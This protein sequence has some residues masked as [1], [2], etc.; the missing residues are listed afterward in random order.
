[1]GID[2]TQLLDVVRALDLPAGQYVV[3]GSGPLV[4]RGLREGRDV[5]LVVTPEL[6]ERLRD[7]GWTV[8]A[9][10]DGGE[11]LQHGD[12]EAMTR[13]EFPGYHRD[14]RTLIAGAEH[15]D[16]VPFTPLA[17]LRTFKTALGRPKDQVDLDLIDAA[18]TRQNGA[19]SGEERA[20]W[21]RQ[22]LADRA[23]PGRPEPPPW[24]GSGWTFLAG[25]VTRPSATFA[26]AAGT[27]FWG[28]ALV[29]L[30]ASA[31]VRSAR[32]LVH[33]GPVSELVLGPVVA[34]AG[35]VLAAIVG[36]IAH[37]TARPAGDDPAPVASQTGVVLGLASLPAT[38][39]HLLTGTAA[40]AGLA[41]LATCPVALCLLALLYARSLD[42]PYRRGLLGA[43]AGGVTVVAVL[44]LLG[45]VV[46][47]VTSLA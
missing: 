35:L 41:A 1:M 31:V 5:D 42:V 11:L 27:T 12:V 39:T 45:F 25:T 32:V 23:A 34:V 43:V 19:A 36:G 8:V 9:K 6:Y 46:V 15:I 16:G 22:L 13:L 3:F 2:R 7:T 47:L 38:V 10:D 21:A 18:L 4:V 33:G 40:A 26:A 44:I 17:E 14:P 30:F 24:P 20:E 37:A 29:V 28:T